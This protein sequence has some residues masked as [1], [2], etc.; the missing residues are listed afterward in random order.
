MQYFVS[1]I[2]D[3]PNSA[4]DEEMAAI[5]AYNERIQETG[6]WVFAAGLAGPD[7]ATV[8]DGRGEEPMF[9]DGPFI[10]TKEYVAGFW[11]LEAAD[12]DEALKLAAE[13][14]K[15]CNRRVEVRPMLRG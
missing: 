11:I 15:H 4:T 9:S 3:T 14:S 13:G 6:N 2:D 12:L 7:S 5:T 10:E 1:V 8:I